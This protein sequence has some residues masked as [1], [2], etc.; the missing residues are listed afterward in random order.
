MLI[1]EIK[2][3]LSDQVN[4]NLCHEMRERSNSFPA[5]HSDISRIRNSALDFRRINQPKESYESM[6]SEAAKEVNLDIKLVPTVIKDTASINAKDY[7]YLGSCE[8]QFVLDMG[9]TLDAEGRLVFINGQ[10]KG[11]IPGLYNKYIRTRK[12][13]CYSAHDITNNNDYLFDA[14][15][16]NEDG[17]LT[18]RIK[19]TSKQY[20][21][22]IEKNNKTYALS[23]SNANIALRLTEQPEWIPEEIKLERQDGITLMFEFKNNSLY[24]SEFKREDNTVSYREYDALVKLKSLKGYNILSVKKTRNMLQLETM[25][26]KKR[27]SSILIRTKYNCQKL[28][29]RVFLTNR[30]KI[31]I[32]HW[33]QI[34]MNIMTQASHLALRAV[35]ILVANGFPYSVTRLIIS[36]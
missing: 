35:V 4:N 25:H 27:E 14:L 3:N 9:V 33:A 5:S 23:E 28:V 30:H 19:G 22:D 11:L 26:N 29:Q 1:A 13:F 8:T 15:H 10:R 31:S 7:V 12:Y 2:S 20:T 36:E 17:K 21:I 24:L 32:L 18:G 34:L 16:I 6:L